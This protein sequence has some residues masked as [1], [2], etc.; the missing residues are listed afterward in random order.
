MNSN[1]TNFSAQE[2]G[3]KFNLRH[4]SIQLG[5]IAIGVPTLVLILFG[6][7]QVRVQTI[8]LE[9]Q[10]DDSLKNEAVQLSA[11]LSTALFNFD[12]ETLIVTC[13][14]ALKKPEI[15]K[16]TIWDMD[17]KYTELEDKEYRKKSIEAGTK[18]IE[19][20]ISFDNEAL[21]KLEVVSTMLFLDR[22]IQALKLNSFLQVVILDLILGFILL[23]VLNIRFVKPLKELKQSSEKIAAGDLEYP[24]DVFR[25][26]EIGTL[27]NNLLSMRDSV[28]EKM[29]SL[30]S[31]IKRHQQTSMALEKSE[32]FLRMIID[33]IPHMIFVKDK[34]GRF[35]VANKAVADRLNSTVE[36]VTGKMHNEITRDPAAAAKMLEDDRKVIASGETLSL[37][38]EFHGTSPEQSRWISTKKVPFETTDGDMVIVGISI[39]ISDIKM[40]EEQLKKT[41]SYIDSIINSMP[42]ALF[43]VN[44]EFNITKL[45]RKAEKYYGLKAGEAISKPLSQVLPI[46][47]PFLG[48]LNKSIRTGTPYFFP[49][50][51][52]STADGVVY[53]EITVYPLIGENIEGAVIRVDDVSE[54][55]RM[56]EMV[57][58]S[59]KML[60]VGGLAAGMA[61]EINNPLAG[62]MQNAQVVL[63][64]IKGDIPASNRAAEEIGI[65][66]DQVRTFMTNRGIIRQL[67]LIHD[68][69]VRAS[70]IVQ[71][72]LSFSRKDFS[73]K[74]PQD[75]THILE[76]TIEVAKSDYNLKKQYDFK[77][78][79][80]IR[81][82]Q[83]DVPPVMCEVAKIQQVFFNI[84]KN[85]AEAMQNYSNSE[86]PVFYLRTIKSDKF[87]TIEIEDNGPGM[88]EE[89]R[90]RLFE[91]FF[92]T[93]PVGKG[94]GLGLSVSYFIV[95]ENHGGEMRVMSEPDR[96]A[97]FIIKLP[98]A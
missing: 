45:N 50:Q 3:S 71:N 61:H 19:Y 34:D 81:D 46:M 23:M 53:E 98:I 10:L 64:R 5:L 18:T 4:L 80:I 35:V 66:M 55:A 8:L 65:T 49:K 9:N 78:I 89:I 57:V 37:V 54:H 26:D 20:P 30:K 95:T 33:M 96:G 38:T 90:K 47:K 74:I 31:E 68:A 13:K 88:T 42:S 94:T 39:D 48:E 85:S 62:M 7:Y 69:G 51:V 1:D 22:K 2:K 32:S 92:T 15:I 83:P 93:K 60:S 97:K 21:G 91:P 16:I 82:Y 27:A 11:S 63:N 6:I 24:I 84:L 67:E 40:A 59:E 14:A 72:M 12:D 17:K 28:K 43:S 52:T 76:Q 73:G 77:K 86:D 79:K 58:Q 29:K 70:K 41:N 75:I 36:N 25:N 56:E 44:S 87:V